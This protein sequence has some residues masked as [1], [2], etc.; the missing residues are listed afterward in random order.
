MSDASGS[1]S[2]LYTGGYSTNVFSITEGIQPD[3]TP[4]VITLIGS[5]TINI[6]RGSTFV[7]G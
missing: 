6:L 4:P 7:D 3:T 5:R 2:F 1:I